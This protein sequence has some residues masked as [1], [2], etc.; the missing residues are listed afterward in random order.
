MKPQSLKTLSARTLELLRSTRFGLGV[1]TGG[2]LMAL[3][4]AR[5]APPL[6]SRGPP[7]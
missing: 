2:L 7:V 4:L 5:T 1:L 3:L 6:P